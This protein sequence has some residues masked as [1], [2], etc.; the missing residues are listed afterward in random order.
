MFRYPSETS[1]KANFLSIEE[2]N[3]I[4]GRCMYSVSSTSEHLTV[5]NESLPSCQI[6]MFMVLLFTKRNKI[7]LYH[8]FCSHRKAVSDGN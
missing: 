3:T 7:R 6:G 1:Q 2:I 8:S 5:T 4:L